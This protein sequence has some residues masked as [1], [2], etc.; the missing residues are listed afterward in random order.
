[1]AAGTTIIGLSVAKNE[2]DIIEPMVRHNLGFLDHL[3]VVDNDSADATPEILAALRA[4]FAG[5]LSWSSD[6][7]PGHGQQAIINEMLPDL[8]VRMD[9]AQVVLLDA[10]EFIRA[11]R[12]LFRDSLFASESPVKLF[13]VT[14]VPTL[15]DDKSL[16]NPIC[17]ITYRRKRETEKQGKITVPRG[18]IGHAQV[19]MGSHNL[20]VKRRVPFWT[21]PVLKLAH[22]P[23]RSREQ[24]LSKVLIGSWNLRL[25]GEPIKAE[26]RHWRDLADRILAGGEMTSADLHAVALTYATDTAVRVGHD[27]LI[28]PI[29]PELRYTPENAALLERNVIAFAESCVRR[30]EGAM[31]G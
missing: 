27:P 10:D 25:R 18:L 12:G 28:G 31:L 23:V 1:M 24:L 6:L 15:S 22:F 5:R 7:R 30:L 29:A 21:N 4:E 16:L 19:G 11:E 8:A 3:H 2:A 20:I 26:A 9:A 17:R 13:W 14:Y